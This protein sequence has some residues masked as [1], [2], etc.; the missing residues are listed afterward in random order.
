MLVV[1]TVVVLLVHVLLAVVLLLNSIDRSNVQ[2][3]A[4]FVDYLKR[5]HSYQVAGSPQRTSRFSRD[6]KALGLVLRLFLARSLHVYT[7]V[8]LGLPP[9]PVPT[10]FSYLTSPESTH[11]QLTSPTPKHHHQYRPP[12]PS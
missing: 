5:S 8:R 6:V 9:P 7:S 1:R 2:Y 4:Y 3:A 10:L 11:H 12:L